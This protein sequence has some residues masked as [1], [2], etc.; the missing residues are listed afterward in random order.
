MNNGQWTMDNGQWRQTMPTGTGSNRT[1]V[2][3]VG[4][5]WSVVWYCSILTQYSTL[6]K[7]SMQ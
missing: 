3:V 1:S 4:G 6:L 5:R 2:S 7:C